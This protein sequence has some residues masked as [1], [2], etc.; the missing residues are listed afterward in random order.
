MTPRVAIF[1]NGPIGAGKSTLGRDLAA[2]LGG[3]FIDGDDHSDPDRAW[4]ASILRTS[5]SVLATG[6]SILETQPCVVIAYP[7]DRLTW[8][9]YRRRFGDLGVRTVFV[10][11]RASYEAIT[12]DDRGRRF[13]AEEHARIREMIAQGYGERPFSDVIIDTDAQS[14]E[15][16]V[17]LLRTAVL[18]VVG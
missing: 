8:V 11:L 13:S 3:G 18:R 14:F 12:A 5:R 10:S 16:T 9:Y 1:L 4:Y 6:L 2:S 7:L 15:G 17:A